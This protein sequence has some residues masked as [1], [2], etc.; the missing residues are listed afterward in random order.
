MA[1]FSSC[2]GAFVVACGAA[3]LAVV[4]GGMLYSVTVKSHFRF[5]VIIVRGRSIFG[6]NTKVESFCL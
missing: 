5:L 3:G 4:I 6:I 1:G 2:F